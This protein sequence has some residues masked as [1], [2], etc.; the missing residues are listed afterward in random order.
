MTRYRMEVISMLL[1]FKLGGYSSFK[2]MEEIFFTPYPGT[3][4]K[5]TKYENNF[6]EINK[7][8]IM[9]VFQ[10]KNYQEMKKKFIL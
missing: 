8:I 4:L 3:R 9:N 10:K 5:N 6:S 7:H 2:D 1:S